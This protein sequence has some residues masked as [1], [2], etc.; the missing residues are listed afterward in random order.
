[1]IYRKLEDGKTKWNNGSAIFLNG[2]WISNPTAKMLESDG[3][4]RVDPKE[5]ELYKGSD[6]ISLQDEHHSFLKDN[7]ECI[8]IITTVQD[9]TVY[10][11]T[12][13]NALIQGILSEVASKDRI[14]LRAYSSYFMNDRT[15][16]ELLLSKIAEAEYEA[17]KDTESLFVNQDG[18]EIGMKVKDHPLFQR[19]QEMLK[20]SAKEH[21][22]NTFSISFSKNNDSLPMWNYYAQS[23]GGVSLGFE[24]A[25]IWNQG[26]EIFNCIYDEDHIKIL[27]KILY[28]YEIHNKSH[29]SLS[30]TYILAK[31]RHF[32]YEEECRIPLKKF[33]DE[34][35]LTRRDQ[36]LP[37]KY[38]LKRGLIVPYVD[39]LLPPSSLSEIWIG[40]TNNYGEA[41]FSLRSYL[42]HLGLNSVKIM[43]SDAPLR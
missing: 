37:I 34:F 13:W 33:N 30:N 14:M 35:V 29:D 16:G 43:S 32:K 20:M 40:P 27:G 15:E 25:E 23:S 8:P 38:G 5:P 11:Y 9:A 22:K 26:Y 36:F 19:R 39:I 3:W 4:E 17:N 6:I 42:N 1:M 31:D 21:K 10:H 2:H 18:I 7:P 28:E 12:T 41:E 24:A